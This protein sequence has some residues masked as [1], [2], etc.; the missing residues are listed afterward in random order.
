[1]TEK[2]KL[3]QAKSIYQAG[4]K[5]VQTTPEPAGQKFP[6]GTRVRI[7][8]DG[9]DF[10][11]RMATV[12][13]TYAHAY[14]GFNHNNVKDYCLDIEGVGIVAWFKETSLQKDLP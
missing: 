9:G 3:H 14:P 5:L 1:M 11:G 8:K 6:I 12:K 10:R 4:L 7:T 13:Y 2:E